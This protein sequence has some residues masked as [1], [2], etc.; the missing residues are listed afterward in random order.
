MNQL[1]SEKIQMLKL[2]R[3]GKRIGLRFDQI[4]E[5][6]GHETK[7]IEETLSF[8]MQNSLVTRINDGCNFYFRISQK[9]KDLIN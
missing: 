1:T 2:I 5:G 9:G 4:Q 6:I 8:L 7:K 3:N